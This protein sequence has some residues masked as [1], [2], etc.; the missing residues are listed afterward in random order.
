MVY[1]S[2]GSISCSVGISAFHRSSCFR[3]SPFFASAAFTVATT[4]ST[5]RSR[6]RC[7]YFWGCDSLQ[8]IF[9]QRNQSSVQT[10]ILTNDAGES[11]RTIRDP[12]LEG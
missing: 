12:R 5:A 6:F 4:S 11:R 10:I 3:V 1:L 2:L 8:G 9:L 7:L